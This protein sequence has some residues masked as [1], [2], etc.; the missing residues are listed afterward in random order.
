MRKILFAILLT[1]MTSIN[2]HASG[3]LFVESCKNVHPLSTYEDCNGYT[4]YGYGAYL[5]ALNEAMLKCKA[6][7][8][9]DCVELGRSFKNII[10]NE[11]VGYKACQATVTVRGWR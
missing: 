2:A 3:Q 9:V 11:F 7:A 4:N 5:C 6:A 8:Y 1:A 10:S